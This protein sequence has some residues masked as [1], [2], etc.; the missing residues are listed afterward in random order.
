MHEVA[1]STG[2]SHA[3]YVQKEHPLGNTSKTALVWEI[4]SKR[5]PN[6]K[7]CHQLPLSLPILCLFLFS[8]HSFVKKFFL[9]PTGFERDT[10]LSLASSPKFSKPRIL[11]Q[12]NKTKKKKK[13]PKAID[14]VSGQHFPPHTNAL[15][16]FEFPSPRFRRPQLLPKRLGFSR[17]TRIPWPQFWRRPFFPHI[18]TIDPSPLGRIPGILRF[19]WQNV[20]S[21]VSLELKVVNRREEGI[22]FEQRFGMV[23]WMMETH[24]LSFS[25]IWMQPNGLLCQ[26]MMPREFMW[27]K[28]SSVHPQT[29]LMFACVVLPLV[30]PSY[31]PLSSGPWIFLCMP[32]ILKAV[33]SWKWLQEL[34]LMLQVRML[35]GMVLP[36]SI[37]F[38]TSSKVFGTRMKSF[39]Y[40]TW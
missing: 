24:T 3:G 20:F 38:S 14:I 27:R 11:A 30:L 33:F 17:L 10:S 2:A 5:T 32:Q 40:L 28:L 1:S 29:L 9:F 19:R 7:I 21:R 37:F 15:S 13:N 23:V 25:S 34:T 26:S 36:L 22:W 16:F 31:L 6:R 8:M 4:L 39:K 18:D 35:S 12:N